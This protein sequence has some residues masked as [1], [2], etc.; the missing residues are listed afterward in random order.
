MLSSL[1]QAVE[2]IAPNAVDYGFLPLQRINI[3]ILLLLKR[4][5]GPSA[6]VSSKCQGSLH[7]RVVEFLGLTLILRPFFSFVRTCVLLIWSALEKTELK[8]WKSITKNTTVFVNVLFCIFLIV[9]VIML[10]NVLVAL[11]TKTYDN[12]TVIQILI[13]QKE[14]QLSQR[15]IQGLL[16]T[17]FAYNHPQSESFCGNSRAGG[18]EGAL[19]SLPPS[20]NLFPPKERFTERGKSPLL[21]SQPSLPASSKIFLH[22][23][24]GF[25]FLAQ[26]RALVTETTLGLL[27]L[28]K[29]D[30]RKLISVD[31][32]VK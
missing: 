9:T 22:S 12:I 23:F 16:N 7:N 31:V 13:S 29:K 19:A 24:L 15:F 10:V 4:H 17:V 32:A 14:Q 26:I 8:E 2:K 5:L 1:S 11:L 30:K 21:T 18:D 28:N 27:T 3:C 20:P 6:S 25:C